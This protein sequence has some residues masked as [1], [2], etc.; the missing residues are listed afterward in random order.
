[1]SSQATPRESRYTTQRATSDR[2]SGSTCRAGHTS[3]P[4]DPAATHTRC[5]AAQARTANYTTSHCDCYRYR[6]PTRPSRPTTQAQSLSAT[7]PAAT[8]SEIDGS[9]SRR[10]SSGFWRTETG[11]RTEWSPW[12][13]AVERSV[14]QTKTPTIQCVILPRNPA[15]AVCPADTPTSPVPVLTENVLGVIG[16]DF[17]QVGCPFC[18]PNQP[19]KLLK[20][21]QPGK[22]TILILSLSTHSCYLYRLSLM[23][24]S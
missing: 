1:M 11:C 10:K 16:E 22:I 8:T 17:A 12:L 19:R 13:S 4:R 24:V 9:S 14:F 7:G 3:D 23:R 5:A 18:H 20:M 15:A 6:P 2:H 21:T